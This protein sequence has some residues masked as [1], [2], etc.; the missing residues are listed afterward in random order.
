M[1]AAL[2]A[3]ERILARLRAAPGQIIPAP[4]APAAPASAT[5]T[6]MLEQFRR[7]IEAFH[8]EVID[9]RARRWQAVLAEVCA[10][11]AIGTLMLPPGDLLDL[12]AWPDGPRLSRFDRP[13]PAR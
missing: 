5:P 9:A 10:A 13:I 3:R 12:L 4:P 8:A 7:G 1:N 6:T 2:G 11:K